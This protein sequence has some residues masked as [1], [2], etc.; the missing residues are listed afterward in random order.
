MVQRVENPEVQA[1]EWFMRVQSGEL[2]DQQQEALADWLCASPDNV[3]AYQRCEAV[4]EQLGR[5]D[6][7]EAP[8]GQP[9]RSGDSLWQRFLNA[10]GSRL[11]GGFSG[12]KAPGLA[13]A[14]ITA[15]VFGVLLWNG[16]SAGPEALRFETGVGE[17]ATFQLNDGSELTLSARSRVRVTLDDSLRR[18][19]IQ[20][21]RGFFDVVS[22]PER[23]FHVYAHDA[24]VE[25]VGTQFDVRRTERRVT[26]SVRE[27]IVDVLETDPGQAAEKQPSVTLQAG[28]QV[29][30]VRHESFSKI[31]TLPEEDVSAWREGRLVYHRTSLGDVVD[32]LNRYSKDRFTLASPDLEEIELTAS[33]QT[34]QLDALPELLS[35][36]LPV[37]VQK[38]SD[39][40][41][42]VFSR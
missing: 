7:A 31:E 5:L 24:R 13:M 34:D 42:I 29:T 27:G 20:A 16:Q 33:F 17:V 4:W 19:D 26:V 11:S 15:L 8:V 3:E 1:R 37:R 40:H 12:W 30:K 39:R 2:S 38:E 23:P 6:A 14:T 32:E 10:A 18:V 21:G 35:K 25:V 9:V 36:T 22:D 28:N 41:Y